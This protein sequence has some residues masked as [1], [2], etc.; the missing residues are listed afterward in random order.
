MNSVLQAVALNEADCE[1]EQSRDDRVVPN[2]AL[3]TAP[4]LVDAIETIKALAAFSDDPI[5]SA[6]SSKVRLQIQK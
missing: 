2:E 4:H 1:W 3:V 6:A 5:H